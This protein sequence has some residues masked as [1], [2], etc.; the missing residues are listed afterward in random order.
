[1]YS[2]PCVMGMCSTWRL[3]SV[4]LAIYY[5][6]WIK[7]DGLVETGNAPTE[8]WSLHVEERTLLGEL[9]VDGCILSNIKTVLKSTNMNHNEYDS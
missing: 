4:L 8:T 6:N 3:T 2:S 7:Q 5:G 1:M 9:D